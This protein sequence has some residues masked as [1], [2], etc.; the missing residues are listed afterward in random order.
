MNSRVNEQPM[1]AGLANLK[2][3]KLQELQNTLAPI[4]ASSAAEGVYAQLIDGR[5]TGQ[6][7]AT[8]QSNP[9]DSAIQLYQNV[10]A[11]LKLQ[12]LKIDMNV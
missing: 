10:R 9:S 8:D 7:E 1:F 6:Q 5:P 4:L 2:S 12:L 11:S 3:E